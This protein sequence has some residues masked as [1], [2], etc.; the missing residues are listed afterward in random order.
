MA[1]RGA[2]PDAQDPEAARPFLVLDGGMGHLLR[3]SGVRIRGRLGSMERFL[4]VA[5]ANRDSPKIVVDSHL[6]FLRA[7][8]N[9]VTTNSYSCVPRAL[10][11]DNGLIVELIEAAGRLAHAACAA[12]AREQPRATRA[13]VAGC[14]PPLNESYRPERVGDD[15]ELREAYAL[16]VHHI[17][18]HS[19]V[20]LCETMS[21]AREA[22]LAAEAASKSGKPVWVSWTLAED[23]SGRLRSGEPIEHAV[24]ELSAV[25]NIHA[26]LF[27]C[28]K[29]SSIAVALTRLRSAAPPHVRL[30]GYGNGFV[31][32]ETS[33]GDSTDPRGFSEYDVQLTPQAYAEQAQLWLGAGA[34]LI[35]GC[36]GIVRT[37]SPPLPRLA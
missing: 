14:V 20:L 15:A 36:C 8:A 7:G 30:G 6:E 11:N 26:M 31:T 35:G 21:S 22:R 23:E 17:A 4:N 37:A 12:F 34:S 2:A 9:V 3:R 24:A 16:I 18:P 5:L 13:L 33:G 27:N 32:V 19:D 28:S 1:A 25:A 29:S 10:G